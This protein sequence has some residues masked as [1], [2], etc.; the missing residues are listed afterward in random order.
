MDIQALLT[1]AAEG[2]ISKVRRKL[3]EGFGVDSKDNEG[4]TILMIACRNGHAPL[5]KFLI[6]NGADVE[7]CNAKGET[8][9]DMAALS[10]DYETIKIFNE[11][12]K[13]TNA[14]ESLYR[15]ITNNILQTAAGIA[16]V[17]RNLN[18]DERHL[19][20]EDF[21]KV[22][23][24]ATKGEEIKTQHKFAFTVLADI[25]KSE[26]AEPG[27]DVKAIYTLP[28]KQV[29]QKLLEV[30]K[31]YETIFEKLKPDAPEHDFN[32]VK[33]LDDSELDKVKKALY[34]FA[35][36]AVKADDTVT[37]T[38]I[39]NLKEINTKLLSNTFTDKELIDRIK[40]KPAPGSLDA[41]LSELNDLIGLENIKQDIQSLINIINSNKMR[42]Q[43][44][45]PLFKSS[46]HA[47]FMGPPGTGK[48]TIARI[49]ADIY[50]QLDVL[51]SNN[52]VETD[53]SGLVA[54]Y[55]G[56]TAIK[57]NQVIDSAMDGVLFI[58]EAYSL[59]KSNSNDYG[60]EAI[61]TLL[62]RMEDNR[63]RLV[64][65]V[66]GYEAEMAA[67][68][69]SNPGFR[70]RFNRYFYFRDY[71]PKDLTDIYFKMAEKSGFTATVAARNRAL[72][73]FTL[74]YDNKDRMFGNARL[75]R[76]AFEKSFEKHANRTASI[77]PITREIL[78]TLE[79]DDIPF[80][81]YAGRFVMN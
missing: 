50:K 16:T 77:V 9:A 17:I 71:T 79:E 44:G 3:A 49:L 27:N 22:M 66:A 20:V 2:N 68:I 28:E 80:T 19:L 48:T 59:H 12:H 78:T 58:D 29:V 45:L 4:N 47:V 30:F 25:I 61:E 74:L 46:L 32:C 42:A 18:A 81:E 8:V 73:M 10:G 62:K 69:D 40:V 7:D 67:F 53:R 55:V 56:Q 21:A 33:L 36:I 52:F 65:I 6:A 63:H 15:R 75:A 13:G 1:A 51:P 23:L 37:D 57:T 35:E 60:H 14:P 64:V 31:G 11:N 24:F 34:E 38:E 43:Q 70:S 26:T 54:A 41:I 76:N 5:A 39:A 72:E